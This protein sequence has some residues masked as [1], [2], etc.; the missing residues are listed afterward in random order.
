MSTLRRRSGD[1]FRKIND[2]SGRKRRNSGRLR[3]PT[4]ANR[5]S[6]GA[7]RERLA[8]DRATK[9]RLLARR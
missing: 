3:V 6:I 4:G 5:A 7:F 8:R 9:L 1:E 2:L